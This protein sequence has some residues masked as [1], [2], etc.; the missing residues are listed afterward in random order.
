[1][2]F[3]NLHDRPTT[4]YQMHDR[5]ARAANPVHQK[6]ELRLAKTPLATNRA[7]TAVHASR[8]TR[9]LRMATPPRAAAEVMALASPITANA[10]R[11][12]P[13]ASSSRWWM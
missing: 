11:L 8:A 4:R 12:F 1:M 6:Y 9:S 3:A 2:H 7:T 13:K 5:L 10:R